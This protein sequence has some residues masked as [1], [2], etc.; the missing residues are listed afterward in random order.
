MS[1][2][3]KRFTIRPYRAGDETAILDLFEQSFYHRRPIEHWRWKFQ[4]D[5][6]GN[7]RI[8]LA[9][10][11]DAQL[12]GQYT[13]YPV[14]FRDRG[15]DAVAHQIGDTMTAVSV[16][17]VGRGPTSILARTTYDFYDRWCEGSVEFNY[18][19]NVGNIQ[20]FC[21]R[22]LRI[23][24]VESVPYVVRDLRTHPV[25]RISR[26]ERYARGYHL[27]LVSR[28]TREFDSFFDRVASQYG[29]LLRRDRQ[30]LQW[31]YF[32]CP[33]IEYHLVAIRKWGHLAGWMVFRI[34]D[35][36]FTLGD[37]LVDADFSDAFEVLLRH[38]VPSHPVESIEAWLPP[39]PDW[40]ARL[41]ELEKF[42]RRQDPNDLALMCAPFVKA[43]AIARMR[44]SLYYTWGDSDLF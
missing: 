43:E 14:I 39:R 37:L 31:R 18:G 3:D 28:P 17:N 13:G 12:V 1:A 34:R 22:F 21:E 5:P 36:R 2:D 38:V 11:A 7:E 20:K 15:C 27:E 41:L 9:F 8:T 33:D 24:R 42:E 19:F 10:D 6:Y 40:F 32:D 4:H 35:G 26:W 44:E 30:Y 16:R 23:I 25:S 29:F